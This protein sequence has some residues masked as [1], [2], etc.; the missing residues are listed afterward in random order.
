MGVNRKEFIK[1][2]CLSGACICGFSALATAKEFTGNTETKSSV[3]D[4][5]TILLQ[6]WIAGL[7]TNLN[8]GVDKETLRKVIKKNA[9]V[10][11][12]NLKM[13]D[14]LKD[15]E[16]KPEL[17][18]KFIQEKWE[19]KID[20]DKATNTIIASE[21]KG[22]C[23]CPLVNREKGASDAICYCAE[24]FVEKMYTKAIGKPVTTTV[25]SSVLR[26]DKNCQ[27]KIEWAKS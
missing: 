21:N 10:H 11:Y 23:A 14:I 2:A 27:Y 19:W 24:G 25:I 13:D 12:N 8:E 20:Y 9:S 1:Y 7:I 17:F 4:K 18:N 5:T 26:G 3:P 22:V 6:E 16:G 15:F